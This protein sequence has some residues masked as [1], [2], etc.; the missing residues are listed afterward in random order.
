MSNNHLDAGSLTRRLSSASSLSS[1]EE[2]YFLQ[3]SL[4]SSDNL[5]ER[6]NALEGNVS[7]YFMKSMTSSAF[8]AALRQKE[9]E[10]AS[11][12]SRLV[13][14]LDSLTDPFNCISCAHI[15]LFWCFCWP[16][17]TVLLSLF[18]GSVYLK[19]QTIGAETILVYFHAR[20]FF[21]A[22]S[23][24]SF[25]LLLVLT[26]WFFQ[27]S[28]ESIRDSLAEE[29][30]KMTAEV[31]SFLRTYNFSFLLRDFPLWCSLFEICCICLVWKASFRSFRA[32]W[33]SGRARCT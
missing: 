5:S 11:Y 21:L 17:C 4:D 12:M 19:Q 2:S 14:A 24:L 1:M 15:L 30:V 16:F 10:L 9:G 23:L 26:D 31:N 32:A 18:S 6:R 28:M 33:H 25:D 8:E 27:A 7:P 29:L 20:L 3:A 22:T 13:W